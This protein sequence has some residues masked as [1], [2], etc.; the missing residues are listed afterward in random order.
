MS[1]NEKQIDWQKAKK[2]TKDKM[3]HLPT[4][5]SEEIVD[6]YRELLSALQEPEIRDLDMKLKQFRMHDR[7]ESFALSYSY[8][9]NAA[10]RREHPIP[11]DDVEK[12]LK[13]AELKHNKVINED[14]AA[15]YANQLANQHKKNLC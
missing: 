7:F 1:S 8:L 5:S 2:E 4:L 11:V 10:C 9:F 6:T 3:K 15:I 13:L 12:M 14:E